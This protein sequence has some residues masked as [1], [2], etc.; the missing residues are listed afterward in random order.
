MLVTFS[1]P[2]PEL[3]SVTFWVTLAVFT[4]WFPKPTLEGFKAT[5]GAVT[6]APE[7]VRLTV[8]GLPEA[9]SVI[10][11]APV[12]V[13]VAVGV[14]VTLIVQFAPAPTEVPQVFVCPK[15]PL[16]AMLVM[17]SVALPV[18]L[19]VTLCVALVVL[20]CWYP[21][22]RLVGD[23]LT[24][25]PVP[26]PVR[27]IVCGLPEAVSVIVIVPVNVPAAAGVNV[28]LIVQFAAGAWV[29]PHVV[30]SA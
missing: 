25:G 15:S 5:A 18:F 16:G 8:C 22:V 27:L 10:V 17:P 1:V 29:A 26:V 4:A 24:I 7:P 28:T 23:R 14:N 6:V 20:I 9:L 30:V 19:S 13:P 11:I 3:V 2:V 12:L 21:N